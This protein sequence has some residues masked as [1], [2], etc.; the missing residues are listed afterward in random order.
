MT[1]CLLNQNKFGKSIRKFKTKKT[2]C[3]KAKKRHPPPKTIVVFTVLPLLSEKNVVVSEMKG[4]LFFYHFFL[5][6]VGHPQ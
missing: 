3:G 2:V 5:E 1:C 4:N 6:R